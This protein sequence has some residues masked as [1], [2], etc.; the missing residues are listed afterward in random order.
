MNYLTGSSHIQLVC[1]PHLTNQHAISIQTNSFISM[2]VS[3]SVPGIEKLQYL[4]TD[5]TL[6]LRNNR[7][8]TSLPQNLNNTLNQERFNAHPEIRTSKEKPLFF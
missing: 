7:S 1:S 3:D 4:I 8:T 2:I 5:V 6:M